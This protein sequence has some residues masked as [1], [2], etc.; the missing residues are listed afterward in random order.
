LDAGSIY[1]VFA[2]IKH[3][4]KSRYFLQLAPRLK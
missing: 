3:Y 1:P 4:D 2:L